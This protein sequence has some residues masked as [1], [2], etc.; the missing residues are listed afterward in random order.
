M[1]LQYSRTELVLPCQYTGGST[2]VGGE[3]GG[4]ASLDPPPGLARSLVAGDID[5]TGCRKTEGYLTTVSWELGTPNC[6]P[7]FYLAPTIA[8]RVLLSV[9]SVCLL[10]SIR[11]NKPLTQSD[12]CFTIVN[13]NK[14][15]MKQSSPNKIKRKNWPHPAQAPPHCTNSPP[16]NGQCTNNR[17]AV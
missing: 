2:R 12:Q 14:I 1:H 11:D 4:T 9:A 13:S 3:G 17:I 8:G 7:C 15:K 5:Y 6:P 16:I 10:Q